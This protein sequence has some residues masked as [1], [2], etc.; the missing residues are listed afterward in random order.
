[1]TTRFGTGQERWSLFGRK[2]YQREICG[3]CSQRHRDQV[4]GIDTWC[5]PAST[6]TSRWAA[7]I[8]APCAA[9]CR[10]NGVQEKLTKLWAD[11]RVQHLG[12]RPAVAAE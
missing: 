10:K 6:R 5:S 3:Q 4:T 2:S 1:M 8:S 7:S 12:V 11:R 9:A